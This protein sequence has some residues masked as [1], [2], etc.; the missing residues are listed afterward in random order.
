MSSKLGL[1][2]VEIAIAVAI[3]TLVGMVTIPRFQAYQAHAKQGE[4]KNN[5]LQIYALEAAFH[6][7]NQTYATSLADVGFKTQAATR[8]EYSV[9]VAGAQT[10]TA[11]AQ[12]VS[13]DMILAGCGARDTWT[14]DQDKRVT[15]TTNCADR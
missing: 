11:L 4:A 10:F 15:V 7:A 5:L 12:A 3:L 14:V 1:N 9:P 6:K 13:A 8:Y 2:L